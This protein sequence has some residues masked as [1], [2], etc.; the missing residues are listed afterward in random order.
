MLPVDN[1]VI[2]DVVA[3]LRMKD[4]TNFRQQA[5]A[6]HAASVPRETK[7]KNTEKKCILFLIACPRLPVC[8]VS[9]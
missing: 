3:K 6:T 5:T 8:R 1:F 2:T 9:T 4:F 7:R